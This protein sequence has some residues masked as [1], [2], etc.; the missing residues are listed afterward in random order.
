MVSGQVLNVSFFYLID[1]NNYINKYMIFVGISYFFFYIDGF[2]Y[3]DRLRY[4]NDINQEYRE[5]K[6]C[7]IFILGC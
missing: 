7:L 3:F 4:V 5:L 1:L 6:G 2:D